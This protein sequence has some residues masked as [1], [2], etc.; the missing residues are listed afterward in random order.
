MASGTLVLLGHDASQ[1]DRIEDQW[2]MAL[3]NATST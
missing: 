1:F 2:R 3:Q